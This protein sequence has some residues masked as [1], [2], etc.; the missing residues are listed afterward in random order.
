MEEE[1]KS[2]VFEMPDGRK[3]EVCLEDLE[4]IYYKGLRP[5]LMDSEDFR[6]ISRILKKQLA[7]YLKGQLMH[8]SKV[9]DKVWE[10]YTEGKK[11]RQKGKTYKKGEK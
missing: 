4:S 3:I 7:Q 11:V 6:V 10:Q 1:S 2:R 8:L 9:S 5:R